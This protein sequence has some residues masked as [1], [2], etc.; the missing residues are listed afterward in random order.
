MHPSIS[1]FSS[2]E[3]YGGALENG[4][5]SS[6]GAVRP[7]FLPPQ[8]RHLSACKSSSNDPL[9]SVLFVHHDNPEEVIG[10]S[11]INRGEM[12]IIAAIV[13][14]LLLENPDIK[15]ED[16]GIIA[17]YVAQ[18]NSLSMMLGSDPA[19]EASFADCLGK[20]RARQIKDIEVKTVDGFEGREK[21]VIIFSTVRNNHFGNIGFLSDRRRMNVA[22]TRARR[23]MFVLGSITTLS[24]KVENT[25]VMSIEDAKE[26][27]GKLM[28]HKGDEWRKYVEFV[29]AQNMLFT[30]YHHAGAYR[31]QEEQREFELVTSLPL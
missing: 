20:E 2:K 22:L 5:V 4:T 14:D 25:R 16:I 26:D 18:I 8:S 3:F 30:G 7:V 21:E 17:P 13:E 19:W 6:T 31:S 11:R 1:E 10:R 24:K 27:I 28:I 15:G 29:V 12:K 23:G 9:P